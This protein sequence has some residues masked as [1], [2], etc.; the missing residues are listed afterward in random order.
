MDSEGLSGGSGPP[1]TGAMSWVAS[2][3]DEGGAGGAGLCGGSTW[4]SSAGS[5]I[6]PGA[7]GRGS[8]CRCGSYGDCWGSYCGWGGG[9][10]YCWS[11]S[12]CR[13]SCSPCRW[14]CCPYCWS[15]C[16]YC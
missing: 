14:S 7:D 15:C 6:G 3:S 12:P 9:C 11:C 5:G 2:A 16:P 13:W 8:R 4:V 10:P 1:A